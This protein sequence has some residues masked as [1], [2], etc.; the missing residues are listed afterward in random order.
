MESKIE[1]YDIIETEYF[2]IVKDDLE[3]SVSVIYND[4]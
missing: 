4:K 2:G 1:V 3:Q